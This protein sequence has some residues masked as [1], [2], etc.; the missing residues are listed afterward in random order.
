VGV[1]MN[2]NRSCNNCKRYIITGEKIYIQKDPFPY[3]SFNTT[4]CEKCAI[5]QGK[6]V[7]SVAGLVKVGEKE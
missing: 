5:E 2:N 3:L 7:N 6:K 4:L 1:K